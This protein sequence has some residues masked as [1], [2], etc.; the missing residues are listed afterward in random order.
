MHLV[1]KSNFARFDATVP[2]DIFTLDRASPDALAGLAAGQSRVLS[3]IYT[4]RFA[5]HVAGPYS[6]TP[7][8]GTSPATPTP[9]GGAS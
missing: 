8:P 1:G 6:P 4:E 7:R 9:R 5:D 3:P 2:G